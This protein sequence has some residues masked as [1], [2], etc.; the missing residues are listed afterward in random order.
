[1][2]WVA[3]IH[4]LAESNTESPVRLTGIK[5]QP[6]RGRLDFSDLTILP[7]DRVRLQALFEKLISASCTDGPW[8]VDIRPKAERLAIT[9]ATQVRLIEGIPAVPFQASL[10]ISADGKVE[11]SAANSVNVTKIIASQIDHMIGRSTFD[12]GGVLQAKLKGV[13]PDG[14]AVVIK[15]DLKLDLGVK[16]EQTDVEIIVNLRSGKIDW[17]EMDAD[18]LLGQIRKIAADVNKTLPFSDSVVSL[19]WD[20]VDAEACPLDPRNLDKCRLSVPLILILDEFFRGVV[21]DM[22]IGSVVFSTSG[23]KLDVND[24]ITITL[25]KSYPIG[26]ATLSGISFTIAKDKVTIDSQVS[27]SDLKDIARIDAV[28]TAG[29]SLKNAKN[30]KVKGVELDG[31][32][33][34]FNSLPI[35]KTRGRIIA[36][37]D[38]RSLAA[39]FDMG[40]V[41]NKVF[42][43][44]GCFY[45][46]KNECSSI[47]PDDWSSVCPDQD[48]KQPVNPVIEGCGKGHIFHLINGDMRVYGLSN[49]SIE[50]RAKADFKLFPIVWG[51]FSADQG[52]SNPKLTG[53]YKGISLNRG[54]NIGKVDVEVGVAGC[55]LRHRCYR[56][57][58]GA[59][60]ERPTRAVEGSNQG[61]YSCDATSRPQPGGDAQSN[62]IRKSHDKS[63][64]VVRKGWWRDRW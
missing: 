46:G 18:V 53:S 28:F 38:Y 51:K 43:S 19:A 25:P 61:Y 32:M 22:I 27:F 59:D 26:P 63:V 21:G 50:A 16:V 37:G 49:G 58:A 10:L 42:S 62:F 24:Q 33:I 20:K 44:R 64:C 7:E 31:P 60:A 54:I 47:L 41:L 30:E 17:P 34:L 39:S 14:E 35:G 45:A 9:A 6:A 11:V 5:L 1:M 29:Q 12:I 56:F 23:I 55:Q 36:D 8:Q 15:A 52:F 4:G 13:T 3:E 2:R 40:G 57:E 48:V